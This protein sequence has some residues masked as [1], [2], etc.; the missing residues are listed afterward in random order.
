EVR[1]RIDYELDIIISKGFAVYY[2]VVSDLLN[3]AKSAGI[4]TTTRGSAAG[5][6]V[7]YLIGITNVN[8][9]FYNLPFERFLN[10]ERPKA[11]DIDMDMADDRRDEMIAY[12]K[13][14]YGDDRVAQIGTF[15]TL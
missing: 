14:R 2:L 15:G 5:S 7:A 4:L 6:L 3:Y 1:T 9:L 11:P 8:P 10:P 12:A 13:R